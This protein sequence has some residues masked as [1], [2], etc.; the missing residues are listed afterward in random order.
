MEWVGRLERLEQTA[1]RLPKT[2]ELFSVVAK[3][4]LIFLASLAL[5]W[6]LLAAGVFHSG[7]G[8]KA[9]G[10]ELNWKGFAQP[11]PS[12]SGHNTDYVTLSELKN[13]FTWVQ[14]R[15]GSPNEEAISGACTVDPDSA[16]WMLQGAG[17]QSKQ[18]WGCL[19]R[20]TVF[21]RDTDV[22]A[23]KEGAKGTLKLDGAELPVALS[24]AAKT[25]RA[26]ARV[27]CAKVERR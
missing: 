19:F 4:F 20:R 17:V 23:A 24:V 16:G 7:G 21:V 22:P 12:S 5:L 25:G 26:A 13:D 11:P 10:L 6:A 14:A 3:G 15:C 8:V 2:F 1:Q 18:T 9:F 27:L